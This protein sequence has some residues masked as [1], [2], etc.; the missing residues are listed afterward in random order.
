MAK[1]EF[2]T[3]TGTRNKH[4]CVCCSET[5]GEP[6][7][8][9]LYDPEEDIPKGEHEEFD[10]SVLILHKNETEAESVICEECYN[11]F[12]HS[13]ICSIC[14]SEPDY[15]QGHGEWDFKYLKENG[16]EKCPI[17]DLLMHPGQDDGE[18][19]IYCEQHGLQEWREFYEQQSQS[20]AEQA[21]E[22]PN[23]H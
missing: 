18:S 15:C 11:T 8:Q 4:F 21:E 5:I 19:L 22:C 12:Y 10:R 20:T 17:C 3:E 9:Q 23:G 16:R 7:Y 6:P 14:H 2:L 1:Q 13:P